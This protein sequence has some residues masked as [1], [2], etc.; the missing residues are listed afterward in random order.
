MVIFMTASLSSKTTHLA[1]PDD[2]LKLGGTKSMSSSSLVVGGLMVRG[3]S[4]WLLLTTVPN[5]ARTSSHNNSIGIPSI[6]TPASREMISASE[7]E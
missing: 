4:G 1:L 5:T 6:R 7:V 2:I 3:I